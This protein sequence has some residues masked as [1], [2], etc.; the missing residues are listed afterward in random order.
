MSRAPRP[1]LQLL[2]EELLYGAVLRQNGRICLHVRLMETD[3]RPS[4]RCAWIRSLADDAL[5]VCSGIVSR[6]ADLA[7]RLGHGGGGMT[8]LKAYSAWVSEADQRAA[9]GLG[10]GMPERPAELEEADRIETEPRCSA[11]ELHEV[12]LAGTGG[13]FRL[14]RRVQ[15]AFARCVGEATMITASLRS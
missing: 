4:H 12:D 2:A 10:A 5:I 14:C 1:S 9:K 13:L 11:S 6:T 8:A 3:D 15:L 7:G